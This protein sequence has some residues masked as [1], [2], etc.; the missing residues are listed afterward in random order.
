MFCWKIFSG[1]QPEVP[2]LSTTLETHNIEYP[3]TE[4][5][6]SSKPALRS[7]FAF[8]DKG[9]KSIIQ[10]KRSDGNLPNSNWLERFGFSCIVIDIARN[11]PY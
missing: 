3:T 5:G 9:Q 10:L 7:S 8:M 11:I 4:L 2:C 1:N 6:C